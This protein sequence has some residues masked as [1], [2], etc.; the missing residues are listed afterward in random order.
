[1]FAGGALQS[2]ICNLGFAKVFTK[3]LV[4]FNEKTVWLSTASFIWG[5]RSKYFFLVR[6]APKNNDGRK[7]VEI[8]ED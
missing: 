8:T 3:I 1:M 4:I 2:S 7:R 6:W 5:Q